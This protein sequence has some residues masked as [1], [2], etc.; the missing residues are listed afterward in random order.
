MKRILIVKPSSLGDVLHAFPAVHALCRETGAE[1][2][3]FI[4][5]AFAP[6]LRYLPCVKNVILFDRKKLSHAATFLPEY[7]RLRK[8]L[9]AVRYDAVIDLQG[10]L[11][12]AWF[13]SMG[14]AP[15]HAG[16][17]KPKEQLSALFYNRKVAVDQNTHAIEK[18]N[19]LAAALLN[20]EQ[21]EIDFSCPMPVVPEFLDGANAVLEKEHIPGNGILVG[22]APGAR[23]TT[24][25]W[26]PEFYGEVIRQFAEIRPD[27]RFLLLG[28]AGDHEISEK[29]RQFVKSDNV[30]NLCGKTGMGELVEVTRKCSLFFSND[31]GPMHIAAILNVPVVAPF[32][33]TSPVLTGP[34]SANSRTLV[35]ELDCVLCFRRTCSDMKCHR[36]ICPESAVESALFLLSM[37]ESKK[38]YNS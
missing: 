5:G 28:A 36:G 15:V 31:S 21:K 19:A 14:K 27:A 6:L 9:K 37:N 33:P 22:I 26:S 3:W 23:W 7:L 38:G 12:S 32:G 20:R 30:W 25:C 8:N 35:P 4:Q 34:Y 29:I 1:A 24:K 16:F 11:R 18:N 10:L 2:D 13:A 17:A